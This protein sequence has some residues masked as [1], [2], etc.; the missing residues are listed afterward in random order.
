ML[1]RKTLRGYSMSKKHN[2]REDFLEFK[3]DASEEEIEATQEVFEVIE[4]WIKSYTEANPDAS[5]EEL[6][7]KVIEKIVKM[8][9]RGPLQ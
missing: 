9:K 1:F 2:W 5:E 4:N 7:E 6:R 3:P 8:L